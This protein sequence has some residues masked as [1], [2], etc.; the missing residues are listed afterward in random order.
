MTTSSRSPGHHHS[1]RNRQPNGPRSRGSICGGAGTYGGPSA[2]SAASLLACLVALGAGHVGGAGEAERL[3]TGFEMES[4]PKT[5]SPVAS[6]IK[7]GDATEGRSALEAKCYKR[8]YSK[9]VPYK[10]A[11]YKTAW[12][13][14]IPWTHKMI[15]WL[16]PDVA[17]F[18]ASMPT[19]AIVFSSLRF[20]RESI[21]GDWSGY[22]FLRLDLKSDAARRVRVIIE[23]EEVEPP[24]VSIVSVPQGDWVTAEVNLGS[25]VAERSL[26]LR[27][28]VNLTILV[29]TGYHHR[30]SAAGVI[31]LDNIR[32][33]R[34]GSRAV[35][36]VVR[37][38]TGAV[39]PDIYRHTSKPP[40]L[41]ALPVTPD[42]APLAVEAPI[43]V[44]MSDCFAR[45]DLLYIRDGMP[46]LVSVSPVGF[47][48]AFDNGR[49]IVGCM[50][51]K[52]KGAAVRPSQVVTKQTLDGG[53]TW[54]VVPLEPVYNP[55][56]GTS[57]GS[58][59][60]E[61]GSC[62]LFSSLGC[63]GGG[64]WFPA[65]R[66][67]GLRTFFT[68][69]QGWQRKLCLDYRNSR[70]EGLLDCEARHCTANGSCIRLR[71]GRMWAS[72]GFVGR[73][74]Y[75][76]VAAKFSDDGGAT[77][78]SWR[79]GKHA[80][81][82][83]SADTSKVRYGTYG[84]PRNCV[85]RYG[86]GIAVVWSN[87]HGIYWNRLD[88]DIWTGAERVDPK[89]EKQA[90]SADLYAVTLGEKDVFVTATQIGGVL[91]W[92]GTSWAR[93]PITCAPQ[94]PL[95]VSGDRVLAF[96]AEKHGKGFNLLCYRRSAQGE[97][98][99][100]DILAVED[101]P[102]SKRW[103]GG[104]HKRALVAQPYAPPNFVPIAWATD[105]AKPVIKVLRVP[106][107]PR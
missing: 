53:R 31:L 18:T 35:L 91:H 66:V 41:P 101:V 79:E 49:M 78:H 55:D 15:N 83:G 51:G 30:Q 57:H 46:K 77:W 56:H 12:D 23:D 74:G 2:R 67:W 81:V 48:G 10:Q 65:P 86:D 50:L 58:V 13:G 61:T 88:G 14:V 42:H 84:Y 104:K 62:V 28:I 70:T 60:D 102:L 94:S 37:D 96:S 100:G 36:P 54:D 16:P 69:E 68:G 98:S 27:R 38:A 97:W 32:I 3:L 64:A 75:T 25:A 99:E 45:D 20:M 9:W 7:R 6:K 43:V 93:E 73:L 1:E 82:P 5:A 17:R 21:C 87:E 90:L 85:T 11:R 34:R 44:D 22:A 40:G 24:V 19:G 47:I 8:D 33:G 39:L 92:D 59:I 4:I 71:S 105:D 89:G 29:E 107:V 72:L 26:D 76:A 80:A 103:R 63:A 52:T 95:A 106:S